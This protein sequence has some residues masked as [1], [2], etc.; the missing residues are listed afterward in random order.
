MNHQ[1]EQILFIFLKKHADLSRP[2]LMALSGGPDSLALF[3][4]LLKYREYHFLNLGIAH[5]DHGWREESA[6]E[7]EQLKQLAQDHGV[8]FHLKKLKMSTSQSN[9]EAISRHERLKFF[10][11]LCVEY[12]YQAV[13]L[14]HHA[15]DQAE[16]VLKR[17]L[18]GADLPLVTGLQEE[19]TVD[20]V[21]LWRPLLSVSKKELEKWLSQYDV[22]PFQDRTN[23]DERFLRG[24]FRTK[25]IPFLSTAFGKEVSSSLC[26]IGKEAQELKSYLKE[27]LSGY[28]D[29]I[30]NGPFGSSIDLSENCPK[31]SFE[32]RYVLREMCRKKQ[33]VLTREL[34]D[35]ACE[36]VLAKKSDRELSVGNHTLYIDRQRIF[37]VE[38]GTLK[39]L[40]ESMDL[41]KGKYKYGAWEVHVEQVSHEGEPLT[42]WQHVWRGRLVIC[43]PEGDYRLGPVQ[44]GTS[45]PRSVGSISKWWTNEK[46]PAFLR[47]HVPVIWEGERIRHEFLSGKTQPNGAVRGPRLR[48]TLQ[49]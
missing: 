33:F 49:M 8:P 9:L 2:I 24:R 42:G 10:Q 22:E 6:D 37:V 44:L 35:T 16:T 47:Q 25:I 12:G 17:I 43:L 32:L 3:Y 27:T 21:K 20:D 4:L 31:H 7:A 30:V 36:L 46:V 1:I 28:L 26:H 23:L 40:P 41:K 5:V 13:L 38:K 29:T 15:D 18:E 45:F 48:V 19:N 34:V 14:A 39:N 11:E